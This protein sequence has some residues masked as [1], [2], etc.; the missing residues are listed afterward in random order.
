MRLC[1]CVC[2]HLFVGFDLSSLALSCFLDVFGRQPSNGGRVL[3]VRPE[4]TGV[5]LAV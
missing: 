5:M 1:L 4:L 3:M 2:Y